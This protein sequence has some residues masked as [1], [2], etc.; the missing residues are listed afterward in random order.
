MNRA[1]AIVNGYLRPQLF[2]SILYDFEI[3]PT[4]VEQLTSIESNTRLRLLSN[5]F[6]TSKDNSIDHQNMTIY[7]ND[8]FHRR[9]QR[10]NLTDMDS[11]YEILVFLKLYVCFM[12]SVTWWLDVIEPFQTK[13]YEAGFF[14]EQK[15]FNYKFFLVFVL[16]MKILLWWKQFNIYFSLLISCFS[17]CCS[18]LE[19]I[20]YLSYFCYWCFQ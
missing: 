15:L 11:E 16:K 20:F 9:I 6:W 19:T 12:K 3:E 17:F 4:A 1:I 14:V 13:C 7:M 10:G 2:T 5:T 18:W 8:Y